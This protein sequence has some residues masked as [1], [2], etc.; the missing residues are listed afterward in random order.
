MS[1]T[2]KWAGS[3][4]PTTAHLKTHTGAS[5]PQL[6]VA[7]SGKA[8]DCS[9]RVV[10]LTFYVLLISTFFFFCYLSS[11]EVYWILNSQVFFRCSPDVWGVWGSS[12]SLCC[13]WPDWS[14]LKTQ[15]QTFMLTCIC[16]MFSTHSL[17]P[18]WCPGEVMAPAQ[19]INDIMSTTTTPVLPVQSR[20]HTH[21]FSSVIGSAHFLSTCDFLFCTCLIQHRIN[22]SLPRQHSLCLF[23]MKSINTTWWFI[24]EIPQWNR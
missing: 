5:P 23:P 24:C 22:M 1:V 2:C 12:Y 17:E 18:R 14:E 10:V 6:C 8:L 4:C 7:F 11:P 3:P 9:D 13:C 20:W 19:H 15:T 21:I 16:Y